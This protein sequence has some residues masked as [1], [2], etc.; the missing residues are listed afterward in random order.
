[1]DTGE[2]TMPDIFP[3]PNFVYA[4][5]AIEG[6]LVYRPAAPQETQQPIVTFKCPQCGATTGYSVEDG[7][8]TCTYCGYYEAAEQKTVGRQADKF[9]FKVET[10]ER[11]SQGWGSERLELSCQ[12][13]G[14]EVTIPEK[15]LTVSC[16]Y[17]GSNKVLQHQAVQ[18]GLRPKFLIPFIIDQRKC[19]DTA[20]QWLGS[21][22]MTPARLREIVLIRDFS[23]VYTPYWTFESISSATW[24]AEV[25][26]EVTERYYDNGEWKTRTRIDWRWES[27]KVRRRFSDL[28]VCGTRK[29]SQ[30]HLNAISNFNLND[31]VIYNP[32]YLA[33]ILAQSYDIQLEAAWEMARDIIREETRSDCRNQASTSRIR[34]FSMQLDFSDESWRYILL[35]VYVAVYRYADKP[36]QVMINGQ[37]GAISGQRPVDWTKVWT[38]IGLSLAPGILVGLIGLLT[39][40]FGGVGVVIGGFGFFLLVIGLI[41]A[42]IIFQQAQNLEKA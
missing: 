5:S 33:G 23:P 12:S 14:A 37:T 15:S 36:Y 41:I 1:M 6:I 10:L 11:A 3:P 39:I 42:F 18:T 29:L 35:P 34:N 28:L 21:S 31:L 8:L 25:G 4:K 2:F 19:H 20:Q 7:G 32:K 38:V 27:G 17:C 26:H 24:K 30:F 16:P 13:C 9:E 40:L 22:W